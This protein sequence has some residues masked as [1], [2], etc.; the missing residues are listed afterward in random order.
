MQIMY[1]ASISHY[2]QNRI[3]TYLEFLPLLIMWALKHDGKRYIHKVK[4]W[5]NSPF[6]SQS[7]SKPQSKECDDFATLCSIKKLHDHFHYCVYNCLSSSNNSEALLPHINMIVP[8][9]W[10][11]V[12]VCC[13]QLLVWVCAHLCGSQRLTSAVSSLCFET[14]SSLTLK[15]TTLWSP[16]TH[17]EQRAHNYACAPAS[18]Y[19]H[20]N[21]HTCIQHTHSFFLDSQRPQ[22]SRVGNYST[23]WVS[24]NILIV[25]PWW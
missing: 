22:G 16:Q 18:A 15:L 24:L 17:M 21:M 10:F 3:F 25:L 2:I 9:N 11:F 20:T 12:Y 6:F 5:C 1:V 13:M 19:R 8:M 23:H 14:V 4:T 7:V